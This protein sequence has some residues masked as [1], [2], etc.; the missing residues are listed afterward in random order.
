LGHERSRLPRCLEDARGRGHRPPEEG[1][2]VAQSLPEAAGIGEVALEVDHDERRR[3]WR[4]LER[5]RAALTVIM[6]S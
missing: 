5:V 4:E 3:P 6:G 1:D 2:V